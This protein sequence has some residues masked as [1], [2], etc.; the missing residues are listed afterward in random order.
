MSKLHWSNIPYDERKNIHEMYMEVIKAY[1][2]N[3]HAEIALVFIAQ[4]GEHNRPYYYN[5]TEGSY[6]IVIDQVV[7]ENGEE[8]FRRLPTQEKVE[9]LKAKAE[10]EGCKE[11]YITTMH[12]HRTGAFF[13]FVDIYTFMLEPKMKKCYLDTSTCIC[14]F[15]KQRGKVMTIEEVDRF[16][17]DT[18]LHLDDKQNERAMRILS[19][20]QMAEYVKNEMEKTGLFGMNRDADSNERFLGRLNRVFEQ[21]MR[22][23]VYDETLNHVVGGLDDFINWTRMPKKKLIAE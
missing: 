16:I 17:T 1:K 18:L 4:A 23:S 8:L 14:S 3:G 7:E 11:Y 9:L 15:I 6:E 21:E 19:A 2:N 22:D 20:Y 5:T 10:N 12:N 13:G